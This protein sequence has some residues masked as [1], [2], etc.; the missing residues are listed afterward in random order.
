MVQVLARCGWIMVSQMT[1]RSPY[2][3]RLGPFNSASNALSNGPRRVA[4][5]D[6]MAICETIKR[7]CHGWYVVVVG[8][9]VVGCDL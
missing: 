7:G 2:A 9:V 8:V 6:P 4:C 3:T 1:I 5:G